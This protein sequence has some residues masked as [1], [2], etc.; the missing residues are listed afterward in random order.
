[1][2]T[3]GI[4]G[5]W[6]PGE[7]EE[8][9]T[10]IKITV[11]VGLVGHVYGRAGAGEEICHPPGED[12]GD[13]IWAI[14]GAGGSASASIDTSSGGSPPGGGVSTQGGITNGLPGG[15]IGG[16]AN[17]SGAASINSNSTDT[18]NIDDCEGGR[19]GW[20]W[21]QDINFS[22]A[23]SDYYIVPNNDNAVSVSPALSVFATADVNLETTE[24]DWERVEAGADGQA[25]VGG[26]ISYT[27]ED[28]NY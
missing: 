24:T 12:N 1:L 19:A 20:S 3:D 8:P 2:Y 5:E 13:I 18:Q 15:G 26:T 17:S 25:Y 22:I 28:Y 6:T 27:A 9:P 21:Y 7:E 23:Y 16:G 10:H 14:A 4:V 11:N